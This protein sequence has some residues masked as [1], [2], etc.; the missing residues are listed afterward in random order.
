MKRINLLC[1]LLIMILSGVFLALN[2]VFAMP[3]GTLLY[4]T[5]RDG[6][7]YGY[8][9][10]E[11][12]QLV[13]FSQAKGIETMKVNCGHVGMYVGKIDGQDMILEAINNGVQLTPAKYFIDKSE[14]EK[15]VGAK[16][17]KDIEAHESNEIN[18]LASIIGKL[19][20][21]YD[22]GFSDQKGP[23][24]GQW[25]CVGLTEK[26]YESLKPSLANSNI[27]FSNVLN[28]LEYDPTKYAIN[29]TPD[30]F[31]DTSVYNK[32]TGDCLA[33]NKEFSK[34]AQRDWEPEY[35][36]GKI[37]DNGR[38]FFLP[39]TQMI[40][41][42][43]QDVKVDIQLESDFDADRIRGKQPLDKVIRVALTNTI[44]KK[45]AETTADIY[46]ALAPD[47]PLISPKALFKKAAV[48]IFHWLSSGLGNIAA[49]F[50]A[51]AG[52]AGK[53][54]WAVDKNQNSLS[55]ND[56][57]DPIQA[58]AATEQGSSSAVEINTVSAIGS[59]SGKTV[60]SENEA[61]KST[62]TDLVLKTNASDPD[63]STPVNSDENKNNSNAKIKPSFSSGV[64]VSEIDDMNSQGQD[65]S[66]P[67]S[68]QPSLQNSASATSTSTQASSSVPIANMLKPAPVINDF[69]LLD[70]L[71][72]STVY[73][74]S[75][76]V[77]I[78]T[79]IDNS[80][81]VKKYLL[82]E[83]AANNDEENSWLDALPLKYDLSPGEGGK[84]VEL[85]LGY[86]DG[87]VTSSRASIFLDTKAPVADFTDL[88][89]KAGNSSLPVSWRGTDDFGSS[90]GSGIADYE[91]DYSLGSSSLAQP[92]TWNVW[93]DSAKSTSSVF[94]F[95]PAAEDYVF[96][97]IRAVDRAGNIGAWSQTKIVTTFNA[98]NIASDTPL[99]KPEPVSDLSVDQSYSATDSIEVTWSSGQQDNIS[100]DAKYILKYEITASSCD[101]ADQWDAATSVPGELM[102]K[103]PT[104]GDV[105]E[106]AV[107]TGLRPGTAY[108]FAVKT[109]NGDDYS[110]SS[111]YAIGRTKT[112]VLP[113]QLGNISYKLSGKWC[114]NLGSFQ[115]DHVVAAGNNR[116]LVFELFSNRNLSSPQVDF[117][118]QEMTLAG[119][120]LTSS[121]GV[122][123]NTFIFYLT[124][125]P[126]GDGMINFEGSSYDFMGGVAVDVSNAD[127]DNL[128]FTKT[129]DHFDYSNNISTAIAPLMDNS[130]AIEAIAV[131]ND[132][133]DLIPLS[134]QHLIASY[135]D[136]SPY[137]GFLL[138]AA[139][140][141]VD[142]GDQSLQWQPQPVTSYG[143]ASQEILI[144][145]PKN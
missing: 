98:S 95:Q 99:I 130:L 131:P 67:A 123:L 74:R 111:N 124:N 45:P 71:S 84:I 110:S 133:S 91:I 36:I 136:D 102:P 63:I 30:G 28:Y 80:D 132:Q 27:T 73:S 93:L 56:L 46:L 33:T 40:Q 20:L 121:N 44:V 41:P 113:L 106:Q 43:L 37:T 96:F 122:S 72:S 14:G 29:I 92:Q 22:W 86:G 69:Y 17:P 79:S 38:Y 68:S 59:A 53:V 116:L 135:Q 104:S 114:W 137:F 51:K 34:I 128:I 101:L 89:D 70:E 54:L 57:F 23:D 105:A 5:S 117:S 90:T 100:A 31:D 13:D 24:S 119:S 115:L 25:I 143:D 75:Q 138:G 19:K 10:K 64:G 103:P 83:P 7:M 47:I 139:Y 85:K 88:P 125:P 50:S 78:K 48:D 76:S 141:F 60:V 82:A 66:S 112:A 52:K 77:F 35:L 26:I 8:N 2:S 140:K 142:A 120:T 129:G 134:G 144:I 6:E 81:L 15:L 127:S 12:F 109:F 18:I 4:R 94:M 62:T 3:V 126:A 32:D 58:S 21:N 61:K 55:L 107:I 1:V 97:R 11:L 49:N 16:I 42:T 108:C 145:Q 65:D 87:E 39:Y 9:T 118:G